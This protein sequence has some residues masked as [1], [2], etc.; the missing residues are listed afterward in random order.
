MSYAKVQYTQT[1]TESTRAVPFPYL[2]KTHV[3]VY[4]DGVLKTVDVDYVWLGDH[5]IDF[6]FTPAVGQIITIQRES[7]RS[8]RVVNF[9]DASVLTEVDLDNDSLQTF[10]I[11]QEA[12]D[13]ADDGLRIGSSS[14]YDA[15]TKRVTNAADPVNNQDLMTKGYADSHYG[16]VTAT[17]NDNAITQAKMADNSVGTAE[18]I[19]GTVTNFKLATNAVTTAKITDANVTTAKIADANVTTVKIADAS[20]TMAKLATAIAQQLVGHQAPRVL[21]LK[22]QNESASPTTKF[23]LS[24]T[25]VVAYSPANGDSAFGWNIS[26]LTNDTSVSGPAANGRDQSAAFGN[27]TW[28][29]L[30]FIYNGTTWATLS[31]LTAPPTGPTLPSGYTYWAYAATIRKNASGNLKRHYIFNN[32]VY[33]DEDSATNNRILNAGTATTFTSV[34]ASSLIPPNTRLGI[35]TLAVSASHA[36]AGTALDMSLRPGGMTNSNVIAVY[37]T[38]QVTNVAV[39]NSMI[40]TFPV[41]DTQTLDYKLTTTPGA[42]GGFIEVVG[43]EVPN[44]G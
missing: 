26:T 9:Q 22:G 40:S 43:Y 37:L 38:A 39:K 25:A 20:I 14:H 28:I 8:T 30:Y 4:V 42:G 3:K 6:N 21:G 10:Y 36:S 17:I 15:L 11:S 2:L 5:F 41:S 24:A 1:G 16:A 29:H 18:L 12:F 44:G 27:S 32:K 13:V 19:D 23:E 7:S 33:Y 31:S 35:F 34:D